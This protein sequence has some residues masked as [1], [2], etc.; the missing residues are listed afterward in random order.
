M[1]RKTSDHETIENL[2]FIINKLNRYIPIVLLILGSI[3]HILNI[4]IF[5]CPLFETNPSPIYLISG[6]IA[7]FVSLYVDLITPFL[8]T[9]NLDPT[10]K[11]NILSCAGRLFTSS[12]NA[13]IRSWSSLYLAKRTIVITIIIC[14]ICPYSQVFYC[15]TISRENICT[16]TNQTCKVVNDIILIL[17]NFGLPPILMVTIDILTIRNV[18]YLDQN[19]SNCRRRH[20]RRDIQLIRLLFIQVVSLIFIWNTN[21]STKNLFIFDDIHEK[22]FNNDSFWQFYDSSFY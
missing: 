7:S 1:T 13:Y 19:F 8:A 9:Y 3:D 11:S 17:C 4:I 20:R 2:S 15:Y 12:N 6:S 22:Q 18:Q 14:F 21:N 5:T 10:Q 16:Q